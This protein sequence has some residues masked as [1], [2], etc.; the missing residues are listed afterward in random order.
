MQAD[1][2]RKRFVRGAKFDL[3]TGVVFTKYEHQPGVIEHV[4]IYKCLIASAGFLCTG[5]GYGFYSNRYI[6]QEIW[7]ASHRIAEG[8][9]E[10]IPWLCALRVEAN[11][12]FFAEHFAA[13]ELFGLQCFK[14]ICDIGRVVN[15]SASYCALGLTVHGGPAHTHTHTYIIYMHTYDIACKSYIVARVSPGRTMQLFK[16]WC[17]RRFQQNK[18]SARMAEGYAPKNMH[19]DPCSSWSRP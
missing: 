16:P 2:I 9:D 11:S 14:R 18:V 19:R 5:F 8:L 1:C 3:V 7:K 13:S 4:Q 12:H 10:F 6:H 15:V 17:V